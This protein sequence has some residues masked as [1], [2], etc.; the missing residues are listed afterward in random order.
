MCHEEVLLGYAP[1]KV[2]STY[3][4][5]PLYALNDV[6]EYSLIGTHVERF[7]HLS[8]RPAGRFFV[9]SRTVS[10]I[11]SRTKGRHPEC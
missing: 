4:E 11:K 3:E 9:G 10:A 8:K 7:L 5:V 6:R 2:R 1:N